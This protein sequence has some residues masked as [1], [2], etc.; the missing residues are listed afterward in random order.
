MFNAFTRR[1]V[2]AVAATLAAGSLLLAGCSGTDSGETSSSEITVQVPTG[3]DAVYNSF[4][5]VFEEQHPGI[6]VTLQTVSQTA[7]TGSNLQVLTSNNAPDVAVVPTNTQVYTKLIAGDQ[8][9]PLDDVW[10]NADLANRY[11]GNLVSALTTGGTPYV[12]STVSTIYNVVYYNKPMFEEAG[13]TVPDDHRIGSVDDLVEIANKLKAIGKQGLSVGAADNYQ[14]SWMVDAFL[15]TAATEDQLSNYLTSWENADTPVTANY[16]DEPFVDS[17]KQLQTLGQRGVF[18][19]GFLGQTVAQAESNFAQGQSGM[20]LDGS[21]SA[22]N[23]EKAG[24]NFEYDFLLLPPVDPSAKTQVTLYNGDAAA[25]P[26]R[27]KNPE[28]AKL[29]L[30]SMMSADAQSALPSLDQLPAV[31]DVDES[32]F[33]DLPQVAQD[34]LADQA[35]N[36]GQPGW[37]SVVPGGLGQQLVDPLIQEMLNGTGS[38]EDIAQAVQAKLKEFR[39]GNGS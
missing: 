32:N 39:S 20:L 21:Y 23:L 34:L 8:L 29:F 28:G 10:E 35:A 26:V 17:L 38:P 12:V 33:S 16:T 30:E 27:A 36:G 18:Q 22:A 3:N 15:P 13:I 31:N 1:R 5:K 6:T 7:K 4:I 2:V 9:V 11:D 19:S 25:I 14:S 24:I 37:T